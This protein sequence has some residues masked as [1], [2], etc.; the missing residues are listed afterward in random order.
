MKRFSLL[1]LIILLVLS[2]CQKP[3]SDPGTFTVYSL[4]GPTSMGIVKLYE[5]SAAETSFNRYQPVIV[6][7]ASEVAAALT[8]GKTDI[9]MLPA[10]VAAT[11]YNKNGGFKVV[12]INTLGVLY[13][14]ENGITIQSVSDLAGKTVCLTGQ[15]TTPEYALRYLLNYYSIEDQVTLEFKST[16]NEVAA[17]LASELSGIGLL[18]QPFATSAMMQNADLRIALDLTEEWRKTTDESI[19]ITGVTLVRDEVLAEHPDQVAE[20]LKEYEA[21]VNWV[22]EHPKEASELI[23]KYGIV[24]KAAVAQKALPVCSLCFIS[25]S[26]MKDMLSGYLNTLLKANPKTVGGKLPDDA[27]YYTHE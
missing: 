6:S 10:N 27:F 20:F 19:L 13:L 18:P 24:A 25:N 4:Q 23:E 21:S 17:Y 9:A 8:T 14:L 12:A 22:N 16:A 26:K 3:A 2:G 11:L 15:G 5:D 7:D 1:V